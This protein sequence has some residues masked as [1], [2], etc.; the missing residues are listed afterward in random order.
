MNRRTINEDQLAVVRLESAL[1]A[2]E[3]ELAA[4][5]RMTEV[6]RDHAQ[7]LVARV[8]DIER[9]LVEETS[10][11]SAAAKERDLYHVQLKAIADLCIDK[12]GMRAVEVVDVEGPTRAVAKLIEQR[13]AATGRAAALDAE[14]T[15]AIDD[16]RRLEALARGDA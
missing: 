8:A 13:D 7:Y 14:L 3:G 2:A 16:I 9:A 12:A 1:R 4:A 5:R 6:E 11:W 15:R 10:L